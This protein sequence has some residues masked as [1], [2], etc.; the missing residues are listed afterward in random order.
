MAVQSDSA[1]RVNL[2]AEE[3]RGHRCVGVQELA[4]G[5]AISSQR[6]AACRARTWMATAMR[7]SP[8]WP[9]CQWLN[10][11]RVTSVKIG[12]EWR[13]LMAHDRPARAASPGRRARRPSARPARQPPGSSGS[14]CR[15]LYISF[16]NHFLHNLRST[17]EAPRL[18]AALSPGRPAAAGGPR[19]VLTK[20]P[21]PFSRQSTCARYYF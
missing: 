9:T 6:G 17:F 4:A 18:K 20:T 19:P 7:R 8:S 11:L 16:F 10:I 12:P 3:H 15:G 14:A 13:A 5:A 1:A 21:I 2:G